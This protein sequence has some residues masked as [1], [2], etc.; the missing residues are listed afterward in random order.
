MSTSGV[1]TTI[2]PRGASIN[3]GKRGAYLNT[4]IPGTGLYDRRK[5]ELSGDSSQNFSVDHANSQNTTPDPTVEIFKTENAA[6][7]TTDGLMELKNALLECYQNKLEI[8]KA[9][10]DLKNE[11]IFYA[12]ILW[13][14]YVLILGFL[15]SWFK[16]KVAEKK[17]ELLEL[18]RDL[19]A[20][21]IDVD[22]DLDP[23][24]ENHFLRLSSLFDEVKSCD[25][26]WDI[27]SSKP[28]GSATDQPS[29][30]STL[31]QAKVHFSYKNLD[32]IK[33]K[34]NAPHLENANGGNIYIYPAFVA[35]VNS[36]TDFGLIDIRDLDVDF[37]VS[38]SLVIN[39]VPTDAEIVH[40]TWLHVNKNGSPDRRYKN[41]PEIP[42]C[43]FASLTLKSE[44]G[45]NEKF[46]LS[47]YRK[48]EP[49]GVALRD[50]CRLKNQS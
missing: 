30:A 15:F 28:L 32:L 42:V 34:Y 40:K 36:A 19:T 29:V 39:Q 43:K 41:N 3:I 13:L 7:T 31:T 11:I 23:S 21:Y 50:Y 6:S 24:Y 37:S 4:G 12:A 2:G 5:I 44:T 27:T 16:N 18:E 17:Q 25:S 20:C 9:I 38:N 26:I 47:S 49:F 8:E 45:L 35:I 48:S 10:A 22:L 14:S 33:T 1:S 46:L